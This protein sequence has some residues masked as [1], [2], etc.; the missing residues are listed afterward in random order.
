MHLFWPNSNDWKSVLEQLRRQ[1]I[2]TPFHPDVLLF[3]QV[4][5]KKLLRFRNYPELVALGYWLRKT[6]M[7]EIQESWK[8]QTKDK[9]IKPR[10]TVFHLAPSNVDTIFVYSW[11]LSLLAGN[12]NIIRLSAKEQLETNQLLALVID[13]LKD[14]NHVTVAERTLLF[15]Y[16]HDDELT[17]YLSAHCHTRVVWG[18]DKTINAIRNIPLATMANELVFPDRF[19]LAIMNSEAILKANQEEKKHLLEQFYNDSFWFDQM[20]CSSPRLVVWTGQDES[21]QSVQKD[22]WT[23]FNQIVQQKE[24][25]LMAAVQVQK[26]TTGLWLATEK[27]AKNVMRDV[28]YSRIFFDRVPVELRE[29][30]CGGGLFYECTASSLNDV[31]S[32]IT[33]KDQTITYF[34]YEREELETFAALVITRGIDRIVPVGQALN[35]DGI[36]DGQSFLQSFTREV[37]II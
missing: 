19:S 26:F 28:S 24:Y 8:K 10:G 31:S 13:L 1:E 2:L 12:R 22:F 18:G 36:W 35:F 16:R 21:I 20:A 29:R 5:S 32:V 11:I 27:E 33:D 34:G 4:L 17:A 7:Y 37:V 6:H 14:D 30:H 23:L 15:T 9:F 3:I 25:E